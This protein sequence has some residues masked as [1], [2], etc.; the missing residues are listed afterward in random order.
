MPGTGDL[1]A[2]AAVGLGATGLAHVLANRVG[3]FIAGTLARNRQRLGLSSTFFWMVLLVSLIGIVLSNTPAKKLEGA[4][5]SKVG[6]V[7]LYIM[8]AHHRHEDGHRR[9]F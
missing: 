6:T 2:I 7:F 1:M 9:H 4:G 3:P 5:A 8:I